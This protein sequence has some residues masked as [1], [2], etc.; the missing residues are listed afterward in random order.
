MKQQDPA[1]T[2]RDAELIQQSA[3]ATADAMA[4]EVPGATATSPREMPRQAWGAIARRVYVMNDFHNLALLA[5]GVAFFAFLAFVP[6]ILLVVFGLIW[7]SDRRAGRR[8][9]AVA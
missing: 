7:L 6:L 4:D 2:Q 3:P 5:A 1:P 8:A 9:E